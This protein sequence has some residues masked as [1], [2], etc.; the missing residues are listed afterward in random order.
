MRRLVLLGGIV[1]ILAS[2]SEDT[3]PVPRAKMAK[4][5]RDIHIAEAWSTM[6]GPDSL[7]NSSTRR[8]IDS[9]A[10]YYQ[11]ILARHELTLDGFSEAYE[12]YKIHPLE[13]DSVYARVVPML[14]ELEAKSATGKPLQ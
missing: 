12:W 5:L 3:A 11:A 13:L 10:A 4:V 7:R 9:L 1:A 6:A 2:C 14:S 8:N